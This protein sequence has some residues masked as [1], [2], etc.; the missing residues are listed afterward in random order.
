MLVAAADFVEPA[1]DD[2]DIGHQF[3]GPLLQRDRLAVA[4]QR[5]PRLAAVHRHAAEVRVRFLVRVAVERRAF[6]ECAREQ[7]RVD[8]ARGLQRD[9]GRL[10]RIDVE[11]AHFDVLDAARRERMQRPLA[12]IRDALRP[13]RRVELVLDLQHV[14]VDLDPLAV[15]MRADRLVRRIRLA[16]GLRQRVEITGQRVVVDVQ[17]GLGRRVRV[18]EIAHPQAGRVRPVQRIGV[19]RIE[20]VRLAAQEPGV[21]HRR[22]A[23]QVH[24]QPAAAAEV[25]DL[26]EI[27]FRLVIDERRR[28]PF[29][30]MQAPPH[31]LV[32]R[33]VVVDAG[34][35]LHRAAVAIREAAPVHRLQA[36]DVRRAVIGD[37]DLVVGRQQARHRVVPQHL[38][39][40]RCIDV[41]MQIV[42][43]LE[44]ERGVALG[45]R[46]QFDQRFGIVG[47]QR[48]MR[49]RRTERARMR[50][51]RDHPV[52]RH[53]QA[54]LFDAAQAVG[55]ML[56]RRARAQRVEAIQQQFGLAVSHGVRHGD[57]SA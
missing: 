36:A 5:E 39:A 52:A 2:L 46:D 18:A 25:A 11:A 17:R 35:A 43:A 23:E 45:G 30:R 26:R 38:V 13:D 42:E 49:E 53:A 54:F 55:Q 14:R 9:A 48:R 6:V 24:Q 50:R 57:A 10:E 51:E 29:F 3:V 40:E 15:A 37:R 33:V 31:F 16:H 21:E 19:E 56:P 7:E 27:A 28:G 1:T 47:R 34:D 8:E 22:R 12:R 44:R 41:A 4:R 20:F 32:Q